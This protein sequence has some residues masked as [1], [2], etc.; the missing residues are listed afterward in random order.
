MLLKILFAVA[1]LYMLIVGLLLFMQRQLIYL[2]SRSPASPAEWHVP[3]MSVVSLKTRDGLSLT[4]WY[5]A[6]QKQRP[7][8]VYFPGNAHHIGSRGR[9][10]K[11]YLV[12]GYGVLLV[13]YRGYSDNPGK[14]NEKGLYNDGEA[15]WQFLQNQSVN[16]QSIWLF[17][18]SLGAAVAVHTAQHHNVAGLILQAPFTS[19]VDVA[20]YHYPWIPVRWLLYDRFPVLENIASI[21]KPI[22]ILQGTQDK[23]VPPSMAKKLFATITAPK[24]I[25]CY[26]DKGHN[27][28]FS[29]RLVN[30]VIHFIDTKA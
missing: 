7:T 8:L 21:K 24:A 11:P 27:N 13:S 30:D 23:I 4:A 2:P 5:K 28:M 6:A 10:I 3:D 17:G 19:L 1:T 26:R 9:L 14:P 16:P 20:Q 12:H 18:E 15:A 22:L 25:Q 29:E